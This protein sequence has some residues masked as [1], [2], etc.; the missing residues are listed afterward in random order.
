MSAFYN[1]VGVALEA[2]SRS[3]NALRMGDPRLLATCIALLAT[4]I[5]QAQVNPVEYYRVH[6]SGGG[7]GIDVDETVIFSVEGPNSASSPWIAERIRRDRNWCGRGAANDSCVSTDILKHDWIDGSRCPALVATLMELPGIAHGAIAAPGEPHQLITVT[8]SPLITVSG[9]SGQDG[10]ETKI[11]ISQ[12]EGAIAKWWRDSASQ[13]L[14]C[15]QAAP[16]S[17]AGAQV[18]AQLSDYALS[19]GSAALQR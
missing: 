10:F 1:R 16:P 3:A 17:V 9:Y 19:P 8:D 4:S 15:W 13:L 11:T 14:S 5:A 18:K 2:S 7:L 12:Y 6:Q